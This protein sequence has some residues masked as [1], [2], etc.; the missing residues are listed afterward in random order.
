M[1]NIQ[2][3][4]NII[5]LLDVEFFIN[6]LHHLNYKVQ[7]SDNDNY[8]F[9]AFKNKRRY[10]ILFLT[11]INGNFMF[12]SVNKEQ[13]YTLLTL[14]KLNNMTPIVI[15]YSSFYSIYEAYYLENFTPCFL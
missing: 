7:L 1:N 10:M 6:N 13:Y 15:Y 11:D 8:D 14:G 12:P 4:D 3:L 9:I 5:R 2:Q